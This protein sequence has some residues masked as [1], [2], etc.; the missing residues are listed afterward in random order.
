MEQIKSTEAML[1]LKLVV[2]TYATTDKDEAGTVNN[3][4]SSFFTVETAGDWDTVKQHVNKPSKDLSF[5]TDKTMKGLTAL[6]TTKSMG[7][8]NMRTQILYETRNEI[9][10][11]LN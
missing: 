6:D 9:D 1:G 2:G 11:S 5:P 7:A 3:F 10:S 8:D 4:S